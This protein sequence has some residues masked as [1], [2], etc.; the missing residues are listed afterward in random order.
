MT[1]TDHDRQVRTAFR[2]F[3]DSMTPYVQPP[4]A[5][6]A[7]REARRRV[8]TRRVVVAAVAAIVVL[9]PASVVALVRGVGTTTPPLPPTTSTPTVSATPTSTPSSSPTPTAPPTPEAQ[10]TPGPGELVNATLTLSWADERCSSTFTIVDGHADVMVQSTMP[11][12]VDRDGNLELVAHIRCVIG[13]TGPEQLLAV[14]LG[15][16]GPTVVGPV[17]VTDWPGNS[18]D[19][20]QRGP[21]T[22]R[23]Y[24]GLSDGSIRA[25]VAHMF[26]CCAVPSE[27]AVV[28]Q[29]TYRWTGSSFAQVAGPTT[30]V[31]NRAV[32]DIELNVSTLVF[33]A[34]VDGFRTGTLTVQVRNNGPRPAADVSVYIEHY[35][36]IE[37]PSGGDW[38]RCAS[39][40]NGFTRSALCTVGDLAPGQSV[41]LTLPMRREV[42]R[43]SGESWPLANYTGR[44]EARTGVLYYVPSVEFDVDVA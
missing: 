43:E 9:V 35:L 42:I 29:R 3:A 27:A 34:P 31:A 4:G 23:G 21:V 28:Q 26:T 44:V 25:E 24:V 22:I 20:A 5:D 32:A 11:F 38:S 36:D 39:P 8:R 17:L 14:R 10:P 2:A 37:K 19:P 13:Q 7:Q 16:S 33:G 1:G 18:G 41:T 15:P 12:D 30:F 40:Q 6:V